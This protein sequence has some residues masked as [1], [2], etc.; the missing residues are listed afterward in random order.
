MPISTEFQ[1][2]EKDLRELGYK[3]IA[4]VDEAGRGSLA[5]PVV[6]AAVILPLEIDLAD[7]ADSKKLTPKLRDEIYEKITEIAIAVSS[8]SIDAEIIDEINILQATLRAMRNAVDQLAIT[9]DFVLID[10]NKTPKLDQ[11][12][13]AIVKGDTKIRSI[14]AASII[15]KVT[16]DRMMIEFDK[17]FPNYNF[18]QHKGYGTIAHRHAIEKYGPCEIHR[19]SF[20]LQSSSVQIGKIGEAIAIENLEKLG[21]ELVAQNYR[22]RFG[23][24]DIIAKLGRQIVFIEVK[25]RRS[26]R[27]GLPQESVTIAKQ[28]QISKIALDFLSENDLFQSPCRFDVIAIQLSKSNRLIKFQ[29]I[30]NAFEFQP[31]DQIGN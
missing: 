18:A 22:N 31:P 19:R 12:N 11:R 25:T 30:E 4:G 29:Q 3:L 23:E 20:K 15:A 27:F 26:I 21:Y 7:L 6:A 5:G 16:R 17:I 8:A 10:G 1:S 14:S 13:R 24:I 9:P 28:K 2:I